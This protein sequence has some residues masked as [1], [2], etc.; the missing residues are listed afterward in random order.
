MENRS[1]FVSGDLNTI[2]PVNSICIERGAC[3]IV[4]DI[5]GTGDPVLFIQG[6]GLHGDGWLP[7]VTELASEFRCLTFDN[8]GMG[9]SQPVTQ[10]LSIE[11]MAEDCLAL[12]DSQGW[13]RAHIVG[14]SMGGLIA[15]CLALTAPNRTRSLALLCTA[16]NG[17]DLSKLTPALI[18]IGLRTRIGTR[19]L[20]RRAFLELVLSPQSLGQKDLDQFAERLAPLFGHDL[21]DQPPIVMQ[22]L[23][24]LSRYDATP[25]LQALQSIPTLVVSSK[26]DRIARPELGRALAQ[27]I[28]NARYIELPNAAHGVTIE[29]P[30]LINPLL[31][32]HFK[33]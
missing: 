1:W 31:R 23:R 16:A 10:P 27:A 32:D 33:V 7:Q 22:Q 19:R 9:R 29:S 5:R 28:P 11:G 24:A 14:H 8:R 6:V 12:M 4:G 13:D 26:H 18:W 2:A 21:A 17:G 3:R 15:Q 20:R 25:R 30:E